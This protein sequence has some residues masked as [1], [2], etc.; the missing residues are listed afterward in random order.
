M[1]QSGAQ[2][3]NFGT[4][5]LHLAYVAAGK[6]DGKFHAGLRAWDV[7]AA[8]LMIKHAGGMLTDWKGE[9]LNL[10]TLDIID[11]LAS[12]GP[13]HPHM[14]AIIKKSQENDSVGQ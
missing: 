12:N 7:A 2:V 9:P 4:S 1:I 8:S 5:V 14:L 6:F 11:V 3:D 13:L 10:L